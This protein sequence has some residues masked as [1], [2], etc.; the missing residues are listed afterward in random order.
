[1]LE[2]QVLSIHVASSQSLADRPDFLTSL[3]AQTNPSYQVTYVDLGSGDTSTGVKIDLVRPDVVRL[4]TFRNVGVVRGQNQAIAMALGRWSREDL[5]QR[6]VVLSRPEV[7]FDT[8]FC[9]VMQRV[10][11]ERPELMIAGPKIFRAENIAPVDG[12][13]VELQYTEQL[14]HAGIGITRGRTLV[15]LGEGGQDVGQFDAGTG[16]SCFSD[17]CV[18]IR[19]SFLEQ[20][21]LGEH[22]W[23]DP[24]LPSFV[25]VLDLCWR[26]LR[27]GAQPQLIPE[28]KVWFAPR[29]LG[30]ATRRAWRERYVP[31]EWRKNI[32]DV[33]LRL[34]H[35]PWV[36]LSQL[37]YRVSR[38]FA[39]RYWEERLRAELG[40]TSV[41]PDLKKTRK[42]G[43]AMPLTE[44]R[45]W[46]LS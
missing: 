13:W 27:L 19:A 35:A 15:F 17:A 30:E 32:D 44:R 46:F 38:L 28:A 34:V 24:R 3:E 36:A 5:S 4:R 37:R 23:L 40:V 14:H 20:L 2:A 18:V 25:S 21:L 7:A 31:S 26:A 41:V 43:R 12:D 33:A 1:M 39:G 10:F 11:A 45:R 29:E 6:L 16:V 8:R 42:S 22:T 9:E